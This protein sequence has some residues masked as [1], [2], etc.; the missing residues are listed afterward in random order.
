MVKTDSKK[1]KFVLQTDLTGICV[2]RE[3]LFEFKILVSLNVFYLETWMCLIWA[4]SGHL[5]ETYSE[6]C[7]TSKMELFARI[8]NSWMSLIIFAKKLHLLILDVCHG[9]C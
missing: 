9:F 4:L 3:A 1:G 5:S 8:V 2:K 6:H 7:Q